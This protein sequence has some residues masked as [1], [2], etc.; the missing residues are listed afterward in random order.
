VP[1]VRDVDPLRTGNAPREQ[2]GHRQETRHVELA[3]DN[4][5]GR[6]DL[7]EHGDRVR[8]RSRLGILMRPV[9]ARVRFDQ[10]GETSRQLRV[11]A[12]RSEERMPEPDGSRR[13]HPLSCRGTL[14][15]LHALL[16]RGVPLHTIEHRIQQYQTADALRRDERGL[17]DDAPTMDNPTNTA[18]SIPSRSSSASKSALCV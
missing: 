2:I 15:I 3:D 11:A 5:R 4:G 8:V 10:R 14:R 9:E 16:G 1:G 13:G 7:L 17:E 6:A 18:L 12:R